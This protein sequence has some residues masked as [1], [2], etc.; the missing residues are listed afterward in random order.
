MP[1]TAPADLASAHRWFG[2]ELNNLAWSLIEA[3]SRTAEEADLLIHAAHASVYH[4]MQVGQDIHRL[5]GLCLLAA[6]HAANGDGPSALRYAR[7]CVALADENPA[8]ISDFDRATAIGAL[9]KAQALAKD[10]AAPTTRSKALAAADKL[11]RDD[12][13][14]F[15]QL[16]G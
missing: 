4:W 3:P 9:A 15:D 6:A 14:V 7:I 2:V 5:R 13:A 16:F 1:T 12:R 10:S 8:G 11:D